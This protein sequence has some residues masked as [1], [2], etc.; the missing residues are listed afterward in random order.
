VSMRHL[1][2]NSPQMIPLSKEQTINLAKNT[3][4]SMTSINTSLD[5][6]KVTRKTDENPNR[7]AIP[8]S[9]RLAKNRPARSYFVGG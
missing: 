3:C 2:D 7:A 1:N 9:K 6:K 4:Q 5:H 8:K